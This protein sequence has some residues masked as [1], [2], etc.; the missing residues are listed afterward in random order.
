MAALMLR[1]SVISFLD[2]ITHV[3]NIE[4][5]LEDIIVNEKSEIIGKTIG[6]LKISEKF[7][8]IILAI[9]KHQNN[10]LAFN[11]GPEV[12]LEEGDSFLVLGTAPQI[13]DLRSY[14]KDDGERLTCCP[15]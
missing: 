10:Y 7:G 12:V 14:A 13:H 11:P 6:E 1:P 5:D 4:F 2:V 8:L 9:K 15:Y 3:G